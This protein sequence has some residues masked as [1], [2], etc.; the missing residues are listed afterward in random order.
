[1]G[2]LKEDLMVGVY[3]LEY[4]LGDHLENV[5]VD[6]M[7]E[8]LVYCWDD[9]SGLGLD[10]MESLLVMCWESHWAGCLVIGLANHSVFVS[11]GWMDYLWELGWVLLSVDQW[12]YLLD[13]L[14]DLVLVYLLGRLLDHLEHL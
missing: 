2:S 3:E 11:V 13:D 9:W 4:L 14:L 8:Q 12:D 5:M 10:Q 7:V 6:S 1:M